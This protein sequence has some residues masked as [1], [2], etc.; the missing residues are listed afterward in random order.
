MMN[1]R[2]ETFLLCQFSN[3]ITHLGILHLSTFF[4]RKMKNIAAYSLNL[5]SSLVCSFKTIFPKITKKGKATSV[6]NIPI[7]C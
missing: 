5:K 7:K 6:E 3:T 2:V 4:V 1:I